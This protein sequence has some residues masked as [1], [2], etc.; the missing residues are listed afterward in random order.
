MNIGKM[1]ANAG[2]KEIRS[3]T[4]N[5]LSTKIQ[6]ELSGEQKS[7]FVALNGCSLNLSPSISL[8]L[9]RLEKKKQK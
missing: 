1:T 2:D 4:A 9:F 3:H 6:K 7:Q 5:A 8:L